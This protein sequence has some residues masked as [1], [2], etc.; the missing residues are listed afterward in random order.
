[1][2]SVEKQIKIQESGADQMKAQYTQELQRL[3][4]LVR[5]KEEIIGKLQREKC[6]TQ[7]NLEFVWKA[8]TSENKKIKD[9]LKNTKSSKV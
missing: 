4:H 3:K 8:A 1:M 9:A 6:A 5:K 7:D 2:A